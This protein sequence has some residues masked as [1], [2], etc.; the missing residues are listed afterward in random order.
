MIAPDQGVLYVDNLKE[1]A[2]TATQLSSDSQQ[3]N[4][5]SSQ[6]IELM[7]FHCNWQV[8]MRLFEELLGQLTH[9]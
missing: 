6:G 4:L 3:R 5:L 2:S 1:M 9:A 7:K 8:Q